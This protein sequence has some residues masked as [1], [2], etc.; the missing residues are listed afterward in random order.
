MAQR[1]HREWVSLALGA[2]LIVLTWPQA[3]VASVVVLT[4][5]KDNTLIENPEGNRSAGFAPYIFVG[6][7]ANVDP[8][9]GDP[10]N[11]L[12][13]G[14]LA[15][16]V[17]GTIPAGAT[18]TSATLRM[19]VEEAADGSG[20]RVASVHRVLADWGE[21]GS[22]GGGPGGGQGSPAQPG[23]ATW[24]HRFYDTDFWDT[25]G[26]DFTL[27]PSAVSFVDRKE[28]FHRWEST[29]AL[30]A[31]V[32]SWLDAPSS[33]F[34][35]VIIGDESTPKTP[36]RYTSDEGDSE[37]RPVL[38]VI[39]TLNAAD[40]D[41]DVIDDSADNCPA[42]FNPNQ[43]D[44]DGDCVGDVC[45]TNPVFVVSADL[46]DE[47][48][49]ETIQDAVDSVVESG[50]R[51][52]IRPGSY[53]ENVIVDSNR[54]LTIAGSEGAI[55]MTV[56]D[57]AFI[58][59]FR[60]LSTCPD[61]AHVVQNLTIYG[62]IEALGPTQLS[63]LNLDGGSCG[64]CLGSGTH[65]VE[66]VRTDVK[67]GTNDAVYVAPGAN[68]SLS[69]STLEGAFLAGLSV[70]GT[71]EVQ[72]SL[73]A[74]SLYGVVMASTGQVDLKH[75]TVAGNNGPG[76][77]NA[78]GGAVT[79]SH[80]IVWGNTGLALVNV[81]CSQVSWSDIESVDCLGNNIS[82]DPIFVPGGYCDVLFLSPVLDNG[83][84]PALYT[85]VPCL[86]LLG[87]PRLQDHDGDGLARV[88]MGACE[89]ASPSLDEVTNALWLGEQT[90][91]WDPILQIG[92]AVTYHVYRDTL[93]ALAYS[94]F[95]SCRDDRDPDLT[96]TVLTD[97]ETPPPGQAFFYL[98][99]AELGAVVEGSLGLG[100]CAERSNFN[101][102]GPILF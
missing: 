100:T 64:L 92:A 79:I 68:V 98:I 41:G 49:F 57:G 67:A 19:F 28:L 94:S 101:A 2:A 54:V 8:K 12:R 14:L 34:G 25:P 99:T 37:L 52:E 76:V 71:V 45:D 4:P 26:G 89:A 80:S 42:V 13:R 43:L 78:A 53:L 97:G 60:L 40:S 24:L 46:K 22:G 36:K 48:D 75:S 32:Q 1:C 66:D 81:P 55:S 56:V 47:P 7:T 44:S 27:L 90:L 50:T 96:D 93:S 31:D 102:C 33:D 21:A 69:R 59:A 16:D 23:D 74:Q 5:V 3:A 70:A 18:I 29:P 62:G 51:I 58:P 84:D 6:R 73:L 95:G 39:Y 35:W 86:D 82:A 87:A 17:A 15:F 88:D 72:S 38:T 85:G 20:P 77:D 11:Q 10:L 83:P 30:V 63:K 65:T 91:T 61:A 9:T